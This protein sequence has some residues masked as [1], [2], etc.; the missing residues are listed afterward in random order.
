MAALV[1]GDEAALAVLYDRHAE[2]LFRSALLRVGDRQVAEE[3]L[4]DTYLALWNRAELFDRN[5]GSL[6]GWLSTIARN[7]AVDRLRAFGR[8][9][10]PFPL[11]G[12]LADG[13][14]PDRSTDAAREATV[15]SAIPIAGVTASVEPEHA[16]EVDWLRAE[17]ERALADMPDLERQVITLAYYEEL[18]Q[19]EIAARLS[20]PLGTVKTRTRRALGR[21]RETLVDVVEPDGSR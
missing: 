5:A 20:W 9:P 11:S 14:S 3:V 17:V 18:S 19:S 8:R 1:E 4:Q 10:S 6:T 16:A 12:L 21:L 7:R 13:D 15:H 2:M